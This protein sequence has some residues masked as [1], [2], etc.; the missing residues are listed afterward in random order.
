MSSLDYLCPKPAS[1]EIFGCKYVC[2]F[3]L[4]C[5]D[6]VALKCR[7]FCSHPVDSDYYTPKG[8]KKYSLEHSNVAKV[9]CGKLKVEKSCFM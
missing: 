9:G 5:L 1:F 3:H 6:F 7:P 8:K 4:Y 2:V